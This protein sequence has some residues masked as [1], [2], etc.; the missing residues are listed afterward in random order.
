MISKQ[1]YV[2]SAGVLEYAN[3]TSVERLPLKKSVLGMTVNYI[4]S[5]GSNP[6]ALGNMESPFIGI[7]ARSP[8][9]MSGCTY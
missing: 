2:P 8:L 4:W 7:T 3:C 6:V 9:T 1:L 5:W